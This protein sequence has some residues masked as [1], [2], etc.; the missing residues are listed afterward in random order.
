M[1]ESKLDW[2]QYCCWVYNLNV[3][4]VRKSLNLVTYSRPVIDNSLSLV[5]P[6]TSMID[7]FLW[8]NL[9][10]L[11]LSFKIGRRSRVLCLIKYWG[12]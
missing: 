2:K 9:S 4:I 3:I 1:L 12:K 8:S 10:Y 7:I 11:I 6:P 5:A